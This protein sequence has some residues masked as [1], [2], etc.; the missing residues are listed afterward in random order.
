MWPSN[1]QASKVTSFNS[2]PASNAPIQLI[3]GALEVHFPERTVH[4]TPPSFLGGLSPLALMVIRY[5]PSSETSVGSIF[6]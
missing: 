4:Q 6:P 5:Q 2:D 1:S 3:N